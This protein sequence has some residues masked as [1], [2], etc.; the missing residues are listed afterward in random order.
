MNRPDKN[1]YNRSFSLNYDNKW[2]ENQN[3]RYVKDLEKYV[4]QLEKAFNKAC[5]ELIKMCH[6]TKCKNCHFVLEQEED[7][8]DCPV[9][10]NCCS[11]DW[12]EWCMKENEIKNRT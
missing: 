4:D 7:N 9:Q 3:P 10:G 5:E 11:F 1:N 12:K 6:Q 2:F 8:N